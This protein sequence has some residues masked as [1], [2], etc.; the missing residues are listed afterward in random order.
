MC[1]ARARVCAQVPVSVFVCLCTRPTPFMTDSVIALVDE[2]GVGSLGFNEFFRVLCLAG[3][4]S[5][6]N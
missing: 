4:G 6:E 1:I 5:L 3:F 2:S